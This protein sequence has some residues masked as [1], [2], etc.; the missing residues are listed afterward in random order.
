VLVE[1]ERD[2]HGLLKGFSD[3]YIPLHFQGD[4]QLINRIVPIRITGLDD[5]NVI[6]K[7]VRSAA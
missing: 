5:V 4:D 3:N 7:H 1:A 6:G 2:S